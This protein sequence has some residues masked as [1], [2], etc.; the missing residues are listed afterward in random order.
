MCG[1]WIGKGAV[2][3]HLNNKV[4]VRRIL[5]G[6]R[7]RTQNN[8]QRVSSVGPQEK[9][10]LLGVQW[11]N[12]ENTFETVLSSRWWKQ[13][14]EWNFHLPVD[15]V[16][17]PQVRVRV[18]VW[19]SLGDAFTLSQPV[20]AQSLLE[21]SQTGCALTSSL[22]FEVVSVFCNPWFLQEPCII[23]SHSQ[24]LNSVALTLL[25]I[26]SLFTRKL[27]EHLQSF[28]VF[29]CLLWPVLTWVFRMN[30]DPVA[31]CI[32]LTVQF[33]NKILLHFNSYWL[34][35]MVFGSLFNYL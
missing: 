20:P 32:V 24:K 4:I 5:V 9:G 8:S 23:L 26:S 21:A 3:E 1:H 15:V 29:G 14:G 10:V 13:C 33:L 17:C 11:K 25:P 19:A 34:Y 12:L 27:H 30:Y 31:I 28:S 22:L 2:F 18:P 7:R 35:S 6:R 16:L